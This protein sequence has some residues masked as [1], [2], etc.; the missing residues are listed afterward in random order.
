MVDV[1]GARYGGEAWDSQRETPDALD[2]LMRCILSQNTNDANRDRAYGRLRGRF[3]KW[4][5]VRVASPSQVVAAIRTAGLAN[6][7]GPNMQAFLRWLHDER[8]SLDL[9]YLCDRPV[10]EALQ[11][12]TRHRGIGIKTAYIVLAFACRKDL[13][14][15]DTHVHRILRRIGIVSATCTRERAHGELARLIPAGKAR[16]FH[17]DLL[18]FGKGVC[19]ARNP[20][21]DAC[22]LSHRCRAFRFAGDP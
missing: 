17:V 20:S 13:C 5:D 7:K 21:C 16:S 15:V 11:V 12:L 2:T 1:L 3:P 4:E 10:D 14:A 9:G 18:D 6:Q 19:T 22:P 8:G